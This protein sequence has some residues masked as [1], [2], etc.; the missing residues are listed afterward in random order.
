LLG[1]LIKVI[2]AMPKLVLVVNQKLKDKTVFPF[3][4]NICLFAT[5]G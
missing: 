4:K 3:Q 2:E 1:G 5:I